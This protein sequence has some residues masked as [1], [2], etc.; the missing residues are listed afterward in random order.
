[1]QK[2][3]LLSFVLFLVVSL[4]CSSALALTLMG[5]PTAGLEQGQLSAGIEYTR[6]EMDI[7]FDELSTA[8]D[9]ETN[10][11]LVNLGWG[12]TNNWD[13]SVRLG[14]ASVDIENLDD[15]D[16]FDI[17]GSTEFAFGFG[18][19]A[20]V[21]EGDGL[22]W[23]ALFQI[24]WLKSEDKVD[25]YDFEMDFYEI[26][27]AAG[28]TYEANGMCIYGGPFLHL[29]D[30]DLD[31]SMPGD[32][33]SFSMEQDSEFGGYAGAQFAIGESG[34]ANVEAQFTGSAWAVGGGVGW[35]FGP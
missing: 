10:V 23:G 16:Y 7:E 28:P 1:M 4:S 29:L 34:S 25:P 9:V 22:D 6:G 31:A 2:K 8:E 17:E 20:T 24:M 3:M 32:S 26:Q 33:Y 35:E 12:I 27:I 14:A 21:I 11:Y 13:A 18:T 15:V 5:Q 30:G 19:K